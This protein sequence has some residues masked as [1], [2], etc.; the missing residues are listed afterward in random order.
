MRFFVHEDCGTRGPCEE[1]EAGFGDIIYTRDEEAQR[2]PLA[3]GQ[4]GGTQGVAH[5]PSAYLL[6][7]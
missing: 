3:G 7:T 5:A 6:L 1:A 2:D 4:G